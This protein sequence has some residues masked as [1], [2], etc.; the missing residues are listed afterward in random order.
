[1]LRRIG[2]QHDQDGEH[3]VRKLTGAEMMTGNQNGIK[4]YGKTDDMPRGHGMRQSHLSRA[5]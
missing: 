2:R 4:N 5:R 1:M 3:R